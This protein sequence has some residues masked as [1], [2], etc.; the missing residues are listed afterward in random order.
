MCGVLFGL[1]CARRPTDRLAWQIPLES[2]KSLKYD[3]GG[4]TRAN[5]STAVVENASPA[6]YMSSSRTAASKISSI[7]QITDVH[8]DPYYMPGTD[9]R[10][11]AP[12]C[13]REA[14]GRPVDETQAAGTWGDYGNCD[15]P[16]GT[17]RHA[18]K[19]IAEQHPKAEYWMWTG[20]ISPHDIWN[21]TRAEV[22]YQIRLTTDMFKQYAKATVFPVI[23][24]HEGIPVNWY[25]TTKIG[26]FVENIYNRIFAH[27]SFAPPEVKGEFS[28]KW[29]YE[30]VA[31]EW[32]YWLPESAL[33][34]LRQ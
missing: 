18:L 19:H 5:D 2:R 22:L 9:A 16:I 28:I 3:D 30:A 27:A 14:H 8:I 24:N 7:V 6:M 26:P 17:V 33:E 10:C 12:L 1:D 4:P 34:T 31:D 15:T 13:C 23:G 21:I 20:D 25:L 29:L 32:S 11:G